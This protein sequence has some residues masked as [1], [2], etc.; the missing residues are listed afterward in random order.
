MED[1]DDDYDDDDWW[2]KNFILKLAW[3]KNKSEIFSTVSVKIRQ[4]LRPRTQTTNSLSFFE[5]INYL[6]TIL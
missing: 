2:F 3:G 6:F 5:I 4:M 1:D